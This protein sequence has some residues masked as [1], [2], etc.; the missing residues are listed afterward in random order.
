MLL[1]IHS[2]LIVEAV[3]PQLSHFRPVV[4]DAVLH[5]VVEFQNSFLCDSLFAHIY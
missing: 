1:G 4:D 5:G 2:E 3:M